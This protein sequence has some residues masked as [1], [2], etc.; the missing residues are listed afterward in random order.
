MKRCHYREKGDFSYWSFHLKSECLNLGATG[1]WGW[2]ILCC[3]WQSCALQDVLQPWPL[4][5]GDSNASSS[6]VTTKN[7]S[8]RC[9]MP[10]MFSSPV[11][12]VVLNQYTVYHCFSSNTSSQEFAMSHGFQE[13]RQDTLSQAYFSISSYSSPPSVT[14]LLINTHVLQLTFHL[15]MVAIKGGAQTNGTMQRAW[16]KFQQ[17]CVYFLTTFPKPMLQ[18]CG[19]G[20]DS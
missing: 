5:P 2:I 7:V 20:E 19:A 13:E 3:R 17:A 18:N 1:T 15:I 12:T 11:R 8:R 14:Y 4:P 16:L 9:Q 6:I 10:A